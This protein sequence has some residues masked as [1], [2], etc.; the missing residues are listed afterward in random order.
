MSAGCTE[1][2][3]LLPEVEHEHWVHEQRAEWCE[4]CEWVPGDIELDVFHFGG[5]DPLDFDC[6]AWTQR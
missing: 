2:H 5:G 4:V 1:R 6:F 3:G